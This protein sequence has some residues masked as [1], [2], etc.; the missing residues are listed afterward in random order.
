[1]NKYKFLLFL[2]F[3]ACSKEGDFSKMNNNK[4]HISINISDINQL[5]GK[6]IYFG[7]QSVGQNII[8]G[9]IL[10]LPAGS[11]LKIKETSD[12]NDFTNPVFAQSQNGAN[13][14]PETKISEFEQKMDAGI[15]NKAEIAF[16]KFCYVDL[17]AHTDVNKVFNDYKTSMERLIKKYPKTTFLHITA[18]LTTEQMNIKDKIKN[19][20]KKIIGRPYID[21]A[22]DNIKRMEFNNKLKK[23]YGIRVF[24]LAELES[25]DLSGKVILS[26]VGTEPHYSLLTEYTSDGGHPN[27]ECAKRIAASF[28]KFIIKN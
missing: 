20:I 9:L 17:N 24:D 15:G 23:E 2:I 28:V 19:L 3:L 13:F 18:P 4:N 1:M 14:K 7:H 16:F 27:Q 21:L 26:N 8:D 25:T 10:I 22:A 5:A 6:K 11:D 12:P